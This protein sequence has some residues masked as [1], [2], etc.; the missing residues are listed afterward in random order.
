MTVF[1]CVPVCKSCR[2]ADVCE[3]AM[4]PSEA[5]SLT[6]GK[7]RRLYPVDLIKLPCGCREVPW[8]LM[9]VLGDNFDTIWCETHGDQKLTKAYMKKAMDEAKHYMARELIGNQ[10]AL[11]PEEPPY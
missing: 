1:R 8:P 2:D 4:T 7:R 11:F 6:D 3:R 5:E 10:P 9:H